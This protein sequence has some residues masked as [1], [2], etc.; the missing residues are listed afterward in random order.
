MFLEKTYTIYFLANKKKQIIY[1][2]MLH[3]NKNKFS[4]SILYKYI[5]VLDYLMRYFEKHFQIIQ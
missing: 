2:R 3:M 5:Y 4:L 1:L